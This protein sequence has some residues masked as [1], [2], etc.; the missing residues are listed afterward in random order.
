MDWI[1]FGMEI[2]LTLSIVWFIVEYKRS[3]RKDRR[4]YD[5]HGEN[6]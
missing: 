5:A 3:L 2:S 4:I 1:L 6:Q